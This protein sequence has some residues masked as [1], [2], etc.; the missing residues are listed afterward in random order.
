MPTLRI[1]FTCYLHSMG[2]IQPALIHCVPGY[3]SPGVNQPWHLRLVTV[4][5]NEW[6]C[7]STPPYALVMGTGTAVL[8]YSYN[9]KF[10]FAKAS[11][12]LVYFCLFV[13]RNDLTVLKSVR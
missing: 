5:K 13:L 6:I 1:V 4:V 3:F 7:T 2:P 11:A 8:N 9:L 10:L 12:L